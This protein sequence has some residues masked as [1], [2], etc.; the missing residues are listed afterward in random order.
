MA[1]APEAPV[2]ARF[3][4]AFAQN[5]Y[6]A[7]V[8]R[9]LSDRALAKL[10]GMSHNTIGRLVR[11]EV[12]PDLGTIARLEVAIESDLYPAGLRSDFPP[13]AAHVDPGT[14]QGNPPPP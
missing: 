7:M 8:R 3:G 5:L 11:G 10:A 9:G 12:L 4:L 6:T 13:S 1:L 14:G 2:T